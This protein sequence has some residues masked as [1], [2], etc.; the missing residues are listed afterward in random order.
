MRS[1]FKQI[2]ASDADKDH[3]A[4]SQDAARAVREAVQLY[5]EHC[6]DVG[7]FYAMPGESRENARLSVGQREELQRFVHCLKPNGS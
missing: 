3:F 1:K 5:H 6:C 4:E 2:G 7:A